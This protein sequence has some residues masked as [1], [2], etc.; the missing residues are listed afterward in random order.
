[1]KI[2]KNLSFFPSSRLAELAAQTP[3]SRD[4]YVD[5][6]R[7]FSIAVVVF[8]HWLSAVI[9]WDKNGIKIYNAVGIISG[10]WVTTWVLQVMPLF[11]FVGGFSNF[12]TFDSFM[13]RG[14]SLL[15]FWRTRLTRLLNPTIIFLGVWFIILL[16]LAIF[17]PGVARLVR[18]SILVFGP[19][20]F[21]AVYIIVVLATPVMYKLHRLYHIWLII[22]LVT[23]TIIVDIIRFWLN[24]AVVSWINLVFVWLFVHQLG[25][26]YGDGSLVRAQR[27]LYLIIALAGLVG[28]IILTNIGVYPK[29][30]VGTG[31]EKVSNMSPPTLCIVV[32]TLWLVGL[33]MLLRGP[34]NRWLAHQQPWMIV[35]W[36]NSIIMTVY[37]WHL[38]AYAIAF[39]LLYPIGLGH[40]TDNALFWWLQRPVWIVV[41]CIFLAGLIAV[42]GSFERPARIRR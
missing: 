31:V 41:P 32:L 13:R 24:I 8:G 2:M 21:L 42:F 37:L 16:V 39:L 30:M 1:M 14:E 12:I 19:L 29:S 11:F 15:A 28:L 26:F 18:C 23:L 17:L 4:R 34:I 20:W 38:T 25:F 9:L 5:F 7:A 36:A 35:I 10:L 33:A 27:W 3:P 40:Q 22:A 6:L